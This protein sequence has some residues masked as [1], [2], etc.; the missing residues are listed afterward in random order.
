MTACEHHATNRQTRVAQAV[1]KE[2]LVLPMFYVDGRPFVGERR[3]AGDDE[4]PLNSRETRDDVLGQPAE[5]GSAR[6]WDAR[7]PPP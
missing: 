3:V 1:E 2:L 4:E 7:N 5:L 6:R